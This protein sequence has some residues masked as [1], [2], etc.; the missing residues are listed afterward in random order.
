MSE[1]KKD[2][3]LVP[4]ARFIHSGGESTRRDLSIAKEYYISLFYFHRKYF[5]LWER[6]ALRVYYFLKVLKKAYKDSANAKVAWFI[7]RGAPMKESLRFRQ[8]I[9]LNVGS[10]ESP[11]MNQEGCK[12]LKQED[13][14]SDDA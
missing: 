6:A 1:I 8:K 13:A 4:A 2:V 7:L 12:A 14:S 11:H 9:N 3:H 10:L 5:S